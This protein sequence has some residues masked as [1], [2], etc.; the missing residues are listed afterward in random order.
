MSSCNRNLLKANNYD[1][2][3]YNWK[4][5]NSY[6]EYYILGDLENGNFWETSL[7]DYIKIHR[8]HIECVT[9]NKSIYR[10]FYEDRVNGDSEYKIFM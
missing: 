2:Q 1:V 4:F 10:L 7:V 8:D 3:L 5:V 9:I 6:N